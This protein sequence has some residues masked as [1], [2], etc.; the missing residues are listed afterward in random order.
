MA[1]QYTYDFMYF[2][3]SADTVKQAEYLSSRLPLITIAI[4]AKDDGEAQ[5]KADALIRKKIDEAARQAGIA[6]IAAAL[7]LDD[8]EVENYATDQTARHLPA[9]YFDNIPPSMN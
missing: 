6:F 9:E 8:E 3:G 1:E 7:Y 5:S 2:I 4:F